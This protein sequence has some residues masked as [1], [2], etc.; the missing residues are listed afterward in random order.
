MR[1]QSL[2]G[3][4]ALQHLVLGERAGG[5]LVRDKPLLVAPTHSQCADQA[6]Y[7]LVRLGLAS[8]FFKVQPD[9]F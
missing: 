1:S 7:V 5:R 6:E 3:V 8:G 4:A 2:R 9:S